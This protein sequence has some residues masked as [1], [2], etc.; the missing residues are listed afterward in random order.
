MYVMATSMYINMPP[1]TA[2]EPGRINDDQHSWR[3]IAYDGLRLWV[4]YDSR[5][6]DE[7]KRF[8]RFRFRLAERR[9]TTRSQVDS[10][11]VVLLDGEVTFGPGTGGELRGSITFTLEFPFGLVASI[12]TCN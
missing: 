9:T 3:H 6:E 11:I 5:W 10:S 8:W 7:W 4:T 2:N 12:L 1:K